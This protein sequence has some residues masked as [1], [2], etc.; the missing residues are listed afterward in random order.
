M[1]KLSFFLV[2]VGMFL[3]FSSSLWAGADAPG[4]C[5][6]CEPFGMQTFSGKRAAPP[7]TLK[8]LDGNKV[9]LDQML[10]GK[11]LFLFF[12]GTW[13]DSC[14]DDMVLLR[15]FVEGKQDSISFYTVVVDGER[16]SKAR[17]IMEKMKLNLPS[18]LIYKEDVIDTYEIRMIPTV[19]LIDQNG[20]LAGRAIG[21]RDW[22][23]PLAW[24]AV[25]EV[26][27]LH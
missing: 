3:L 6:S 11:P 20:F 18:L 7:F 17:R 23:K 16:E 5:P 1:R 25:R 14:K 8:T 19:Y 10:T 21:P 12:W 13:C 4:D 9:S 27:N 2:V 15:Q 22:L 24:S 26:L